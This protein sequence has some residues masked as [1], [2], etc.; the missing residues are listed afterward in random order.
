MQ[1]ATTVLGIIRD[2]GER[3]LPLKKLYRQLYNPLFY[4][5]AYARLY[6]NDGAMTPDTTG[7]TVDGMSRRKIDTMIDLIRR[8]RWRWTPVK[9]VY[10]PKHTGKLRPLGLPSWSSKVMQEVVRQL[11]SAYY[12]PRFSE[13]AHGFRPGRGCQTALSE[14]VHTWNGVHWFI[15]GDI[16][17]CFGSLSHEVLMNILSEDIHDNRFLRLI[18]HMLQAGYLEEWRWHETLS[19]A[20]QGGV[21]SPILSNIY[22]DKLDKFVETVLL[23]KYNQGELRRA[24]P[25]YKKVERAIACAKKKGDRKAVHALRKLRRQY[26]ARDPQDLKYR[27]L[28][29]IRYADDWLLGFSG[30]KAEAEEIKREIRDFLRETLKLE[31]SEE[32]TLITHARTEAAKFLGY[33][34]VSQHADDKLDRRGRR[35]VNETIGLRVPKKVI[36]HK[37]ALYMRGGQPAQR[38]EM[39]DDSDYSIVSKYQAEYRGVVQYY[40][41]AHNVGWFNKVQWITETSL[42]KTLAGKHKSTVAAMARKYKATTETANGPRKCL[43]VVVQRGNDKKPLI[44]QF[45]GL[46]LKRK[47]DAILVDHQ[48]QFLMTNR[49]ELLKRVLAD[50]CELC[51]SKE[52]VE[53]HHIRKLADLERPGQREKPAWVKQMAARRRKTLVV[54]RK[55]HEDIHAGRS[56]AS[57]RR[58]GTGEPRDAKVSRVV[59]EGGNEEGP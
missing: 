13:H 31:L 22:L 19:G 8:E 20:P 58:N 5:Q 45:G 59:R 6:S 40:L 53:V 24:N 46:P 35:Q 12:E 49:S 9:R 42:L 55:C 25:P 7:E 27:R 14:I 30:P 54:C 21:C 2:R 15:E 41:L 29:Y 39:L 36:A 11:L 26:P 51:G 48:P 16:S 43:K 47:P 38:A 34:I 3:G 17:D 52:Q 18:K 57:F 4:F 56:T 44:A 32:K 1:D 28:R 23:P 33:E 37:C 50:Q 10:I